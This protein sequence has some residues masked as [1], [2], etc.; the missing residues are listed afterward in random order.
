MKSIRC[1]GRRAGNEDRR[2]VEGQKLNEVYY[3]PENSIP[4]D[5]HR[6]SVLYNKTTKKILVGPSTFAT[7]VIPHRICKAF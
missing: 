7:S 1:A 6:S 3:P 2:Q 4:L 5:D